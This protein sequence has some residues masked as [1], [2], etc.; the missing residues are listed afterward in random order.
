ML[1]LLAV[2][3]LMIEI[4]TG[5]SIEEKFVPF[6]ILAADTPFAEIFFYD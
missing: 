2:Q 1:V 5:I 6:S 4:W 3:L